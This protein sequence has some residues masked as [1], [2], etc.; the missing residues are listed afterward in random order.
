[1]LSSS[2]SKSFLLVPVPLD[3][4]AVLPLFVAADH[5]VLQFHHAQAYH[6]VPP[7]VYLVV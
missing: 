3:Q 2:S 6:Q 1:M 7:V 5:Q 4:V